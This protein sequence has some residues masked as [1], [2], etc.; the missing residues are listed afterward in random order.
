MSA[1]TASPRK[2][3]RITPRTTRD[4]LTQLLENRGVIDHQDF[5]HPR[6]DGLHDPWQLKQMK[7][8]I[9]RLVVAIKKQEKIGIFGDYDHDGT[10]AAALLSEG[11]T[12]CGG[13]VTKVY[14]PTR[15]EGYSLNDEIVDQ[16][17]EEQIDLLITVDCGITNKPEIDRAVGLGID[18]LVIDHHVVQEDKYPDKAIVV[19]PKQAGDTYPCKD[20]CACG[21]AFKVIQALAEKTKKITPDQLKWYLDLVAISTICDMVPLV[22]ENRIFVKYGL[23]VLQKTK[24]LG[25]QKLFKVAAIEPETISPYTVGFMIGPRLNAPSRMER[26]SIAYDLLVASEAGVATQLAEKLN[27]LNVD[28]QEE[29][30]KVMRSA[31]AAVKKDQLDEKKVILVAGDNWSDGV[32]GLVA[33]RLTEK[34]NRPSIVLS[35]R[36]DGLAKGSARSIDGYHLVEAL[37]ECE[38]Y[39]TKYGGHEKAAGLT[40][41]QEHLEL[42]YDRLI[43]IAEQKLDESHLKPKLTIDAELRPEEVTLVSA[44]HLNQLEPHG[45][46]N[47]KPIFLVMNTVVVE[48]KIIGSTKKHLKLQLL[49]GDQQTVDAIAFSMAEREPECE[50]GQRLDIACILD[51]NE[52]QNRRTVQLKVLDWRSSGSEG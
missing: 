19:N 45:L 14:I 12:Q 6:Y 51:I 24:R 11:I 42:L 35:K 21:L 47:P 40:L 52:W 30:E 50:P 22:N 38:Q 48:R 31:D 4:L 29:L 23:I 17:K 3:W 9:E 5:L 33:G 27:K 10:P 36:E 2:Q 46:G 25:L 1:V 7:Q 13:M 16:F 8:M 44:E 34:Y 37:Q 49:V 20:L 18:C 26:A 28:R 39:L 32:V 15:D 43:E 41:A